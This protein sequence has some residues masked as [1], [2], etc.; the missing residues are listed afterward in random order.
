M[1]FSGSGDRALTTAENSLV[2][3]LDLF[4]A[5]AP[6]LIDLYCAE[7]DQQFDTALDALIERGVMRLEA[8]SKN[9]AK[10]DETGLSGVFAA[11]I[12][13][14]GLTVTQETNSNGHVDIVIQA[15]HCCP[16]QKRLCEAKIYDGPEYHISGLKQ[17][18]DRYTTGRE[19]RGIVLSYVRKKDISG[20]VALVRERMDQ[21]LPCG[22]AGNTKDHVL[23]WS[24]KSSHNHSCGDVLDVCHVSCNL[25][26]EGVDL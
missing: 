2:G 5:K 12:E 13:M 25:Y 11:S 6:E 26:F 18:L 10:L 3:L 24:F 1:A 9:F 4:K 23:K 7:T 16:A 20:I 17:L 19:G 22:Q 14:P 15:D 8:N 21:K